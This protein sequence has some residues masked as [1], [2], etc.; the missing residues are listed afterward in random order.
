MITGEGGILG[1]AKD[2]GDITRREYVIELAQLDVLQEQTSNQGRITEEKFKDIL[3]KHF[4]Y[5]LEDELPENLDDLT[6]STKDGK[7]KDIKASEVYNGTLSDRKKTTLTAEDLESQTKGAEGTGEGSIIGEKI[8]GLKTSKLS[9]SFDWLILDVVDGHIYLIVKGDI[10]TSDCPDKG[11]YKI[12]NQG[13]VYHNAM[14]DVVNGY[15]NGSEDIEESM[16]KLNSDWFDESKGYTSQNGNM[17]AVAYMLD[18]K[19]WTQKFTGNE[20]GNS[21]IEYV[22]GGATIEQM[23]N[24]HNKKYGTK[25]SA[26]AFSNTGYGMSTTPSEDSGSYS[27]RLNFAFKGDDVFWAS[28]ASYGNTFFASPSRS[29]EDEMITV[30]GRFSLLR[31]LQ[32]WQRCF[33]SCDVSKV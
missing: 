17:K 28:K 6:L 2:A 22:V 1:Q 3:A 19:I 9:E 13:N 27:W 25:Y 12:R 7:Y 29:G 32:I 21:Q 20:L 10:Q 31:K 16:R 23:F 4:N 5:D 11:T 24:A 18:R 14:N 33:P 15:P 8:T 30:T 26:K